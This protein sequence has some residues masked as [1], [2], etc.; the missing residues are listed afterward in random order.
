MARGVTNFTL[1]TTQYLVIPILMAELP[2][3]TE[4]VKPRTKSQETEKKAV[5]YL[6]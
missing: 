1:V 4:A 3:G 2:I 6:L 5:M